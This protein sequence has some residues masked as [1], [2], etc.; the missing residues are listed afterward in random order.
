[1]GKLS[2]TS[3]RYKIQDA[4]YQECIT[5]EG[6]ERGKEREALTPL[7]ENSKLTHAAHITNDKSGSSRT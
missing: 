1:M 7:I 5:K 2:I 6:K 3:S 4:L